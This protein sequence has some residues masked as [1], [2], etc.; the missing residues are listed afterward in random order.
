MIPIKLKRW[1]DPDSEPDPSLKKKAQLWKD[2]RRDC[3][4]KKTEH[5]DDVDN[6]TDP[7]DIKI[8]ESL[9][10]RR[11]I[12]KIHF[13]DKAGPF[14]GKCAYCEAFFADFQRGDVEHFR[15]KGAVTDEN[16]QVILIRDSKGNEHPHWGYYWLAYDTTN[17]MPSCQLCNQPSD[18]RLGKRTR[19]PIEDETKR[20]CYHNDNLNDEQPLLINPFLEDPSGHLDVDLKTGMLLAKTARGQACIDILGLNKRDQLVAKRM[21]AIR[22][23]QLLW[24]RPE[25][26]CDKLKSILKD[27]IEEQTFASRREYQRLV[28]ALPPA[29]F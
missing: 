6:G 15:P 7:A 11:S 29:T 16:D 4:K 8:Q 19:F 21:N 20:A 24:Q 2:W 13:R 9:Y 12:K 28:A 5:C 10:S 14:R 17:L 22:I 23:I 27:A 18:D 25:E 3:S 26:N 1:P